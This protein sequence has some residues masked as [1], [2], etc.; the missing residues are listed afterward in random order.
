VKTAVVVPSYDRPERLSACLEALA[1]LD[2]APEEI[3]VVDDGSPAPLAPVCAGFGERVRC[4]RQD[5]RGPAAARNAGVRATGAAFIAFTD[6]DCRPRPDWLGALLAG[7]AGDPRRLVG[8]HVTNALTDNVFA[9]TSQGLCDYLYEY[10]GAEDGEAPFFT[11]N[12]MGCA[13]STLLDLGGFDESFPLAAAEDRDLGLRWRAAGGAL[14]YAPAAV[15]D[16]SHVLDLARF[17]RQHANYGRGARHLHHRLAERG[18]GRPRREAL[19]FYFG[20]LAHPLRKGGRRR[21]TRAGLMALSQAAMIQGYL[22][23][24]WQE[25][26]H[27][28]P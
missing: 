1:K 14:V 9:E 11:S 8:G 25:G 26:R 24:R 22:A 13:R 10:F 6:D 7:Q 12:N 27:P 21:M 2:P 4:L 19:A 5:N 18:D 20:I 3:V 16:H 23:E 15:V 17:W 28:P